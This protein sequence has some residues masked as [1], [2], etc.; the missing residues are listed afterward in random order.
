MGVIPAPTGDTPGKN[1]VCEESF[2]YLGHPYQTDGSSMEAS[3][4]SLLLG[5][6]LRLLKAAQGASFSGCDEYRQHSAHPEIS[7]SSELS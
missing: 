6:F 4:L 1:S 2:I 7:A 5:W 3:E